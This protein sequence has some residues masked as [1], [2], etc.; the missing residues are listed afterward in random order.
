M[1]HQAHV[2]LVDPH[3][4]GAGGHD[5]VDFVPQEVSQAGGAAGL[6][7]PG[8]IRD[9]AMAR[10]AQRTRD[11]LGGAAGGCVDDRHDIVAAEK[12]EEGLETVLLIPHLDRAEPEIG[13]VERPYLQ[14]EPVA[15]RSTRAI[16]SRTPGVALPVRATAWGPPS[17]YRA[18]ESRR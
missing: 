13:T 10:P 3:S 6:G 7:E 9:R 1:D 12:L 5:D 16:S 18:R 11:R 15:H 4:E 14:G 8:M 17:R 2:R